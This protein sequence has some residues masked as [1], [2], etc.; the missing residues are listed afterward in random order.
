MVG[1]HFSLT[2]SARNISSFPLQQHIFPKTKHPSRIVQ[3]FAGLL[4]LI[5]AFLSAN[6]IAVSAAMSIPSST[7]PIRVTVYSDLACKYFPFFPVSLSLPLS[8][9]LP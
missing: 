5:I 1:L 6:K 9:A 3:A 4:F 2:E 7:T 8:V